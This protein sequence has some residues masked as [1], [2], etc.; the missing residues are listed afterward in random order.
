MDFANF[1]I[2]LLTGLSLI[3]AFTVRGVQAALMA[4]SSE[5]IAQL[6]HETLS[7][8]A[9]IRGMPAYPSWE[10]AEDWMRASTLESVE[11]VLQHPNA[12]PGAQHVQWMEQKQKDGWVWGET[13]DA[14][15]K[16]H[17]MLVP[18]AQLPD[19]ERAKDA[20]IISLAKALS[21]F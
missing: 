5:T 17:P 12:D 21:D 4:Y 8:W 10:D 1:H 19:D 3:F 16:T 13:K 7:S 2:N 11:H 14:D 9:R 18:F 20:I 6:V 15:A